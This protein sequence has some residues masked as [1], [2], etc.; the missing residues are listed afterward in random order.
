L[1]AVVGVGSSLVAFAPRRRRAWTYSTPGEP[2]AVSW[3]PDG[4][5]IAYVVRTRRGPALR[6]I[7]GDGDHDR[8]LD[9]HVAAYRPAWRR[10]SLRI[11]Y[12]RANGRWAIF[13]LRR[14]K[15]KTGRVARPA[16]S[17]ESAVAHRGDRVVVAVR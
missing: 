5:K 14:N 3:S 13:D 4:L 15:W 9:P 1:Y 17:S 11:V 8:L 16:R 6:L 7:E 10:D 2:V 12:V